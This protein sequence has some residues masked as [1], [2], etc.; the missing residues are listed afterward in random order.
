MRLYVLMMNTLVGKEK[1]E[2]FAVVIIA[3]TG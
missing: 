2:E 3:N 1:R